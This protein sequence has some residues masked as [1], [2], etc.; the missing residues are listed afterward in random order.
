[1]NYEEVKLNLGDRLIGRKFLEYKQKNMRR[2]D[3]RTV[4]Y[5]EDD[6]YK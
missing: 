4:V 6:I 2:V 5:V 1:M 3:S